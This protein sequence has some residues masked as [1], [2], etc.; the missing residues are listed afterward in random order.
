M[1]RSGRRLIELEEVVHP[2][3]GAEATRLA[4]AVVGAV[5][6]LG[7]L[8][9]ADRPGRRRSAPPTTQPAAKPITAPVCPATSGERRAEH[10][11]GRPARRR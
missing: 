11:H 4:D 3:P 9:V 7:P 10:Q 6:G 8:R 5:R 2:G 1:K